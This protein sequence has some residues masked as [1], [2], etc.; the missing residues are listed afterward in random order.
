MMRPP[1]PVETEM[2]TIAA[3]LLLRSPQSV[4]PQI[5]EILGDLKRN[6]IGNLNNDTDEDEESESSTNSSEISNDEGAP[7][8]HHHSHH[9]VA[10]SP[11]MSARYKTTATEIEMKPIHS[12]TLS[13]SRTPTLCATPKLPVHPMSTSLRLPSLHF[14]EME[15]NPSQL[16]NHKP[17]ASNS[18]QSSPIRS[19]IKPQPTR[20]GASESTST[21]SLYN[22]APRKR[23]SMSMSKSHQSRSS[24]TMSH[25]R[26]KSLVYRA[27]T[28]TTERDIRTICFYL[29]I[30]GIII[31]FVG[32]SI[33]ILM[34][35]PYENQCHLFDP[36]GTVAVFDFLY[37][38]LIST[39][40]M[41][42]C[43]HHSDATFQFRCKVKKHFVMRTTTSCSGAF[44]SC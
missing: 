44:K 23:M 4:T 17:Q 6:T 27:P 12:P 42:I 3:D 20:H 1:S 31:G 22:K 8:A 41:E 7:L 39:S 36:D 2:D 38:V 14:D 37:S 16:S 10:L 9:T 33:N 5:D 43:G 29:A 25:H 24:I 26:R 28:V 35:M 18:Y 34:S 30:H 32:W 19:T 15:S 21:F 11:T 13:I 40:M